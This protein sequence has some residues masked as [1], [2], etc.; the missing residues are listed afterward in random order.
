MPAFVL[1]N[2]A[3]E[4]YFSVIPLND[5]NYSTWKVQVKMALLYE[6]LWG[7][8]SDSEV[9]PDATADPGKY[10]KYCAR[11]N[12]A[13]AILVL[14]IDPELL[15]IVGDSFDPI[16]VWNKIGERFKRLTTRADVI[17]QRNTW[18]KKLRLR[19]CLYRMKLKGK[20]SVHE[21]LC[22]F[23]KLFSDLATLGDAVQEEDKVILLLA[24]LPESYNMLVTVLEIQEKMPSWEIVTEKL[25]HEEQK[26]ASSPSPA[27]V[28]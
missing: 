4:N 8:I 3:A 14:S 2:M 6:N 21:H 23:V 15:Y 10:Q 19:K 22:K 20:T 16:E 28:L 7:F 12:K 5:R 13:L 17:L 27:Y 25:L 24:S 26:H 9:A 11:R 18:A 1:V